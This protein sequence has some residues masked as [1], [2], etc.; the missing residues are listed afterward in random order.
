MYPTRREKSVLDFTEDRLI[1]Y[2]YYIPKQRTN[3]VAFSPQANYTDR[4]R[5]QVSM[6]GTMKNVVVWDKN[7][8][9]TSEKTHFNSAT[10]SSQLMLCEI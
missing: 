3:R 4:V 8:V 10:E 2:P 7:P 6:A 1:N 5:Y 9:R